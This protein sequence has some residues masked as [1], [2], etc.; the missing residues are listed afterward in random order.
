MANDLV[1]IVPYTTDV[2]SIGIGQRYDIV[3][4]ANQD[5]GDFWMRS[6]PQTA[7]STN[8]NTDDIKGI[9]RY[10]STST[11][12]PTSS[13]Y[14]FDDNCDDE[15]MTSLVPYYP[16]DV[17]AAAL[18]NTEDVTVALTNG[19]FKWYMA[20][21]TF[22]VEWDNPMLMQIANGN[23]TFDDSSHVVQI[24]TA[25]EWVYFIIETTNAV[26]HPIHLH[27]HDFMVSRPLIFVVHGDLLRLL[28][29]ETGSGSRIRYI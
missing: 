15:A 16:L 21:T 23:T 26:T 1:P 6:I 25:N 20:A 11:A 12:D 8:S 3:V 19:V 27:G 18:T 13:A 7:C 24:P 14:T 10:D 22:A 29:I 17:S 9:V 4:T 28:M 2:L 5:S